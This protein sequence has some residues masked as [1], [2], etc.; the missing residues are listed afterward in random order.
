M[1]F[2]L[3]FIS[4]ALSFALPQD[5]SK[6][7]V[8]GSGRPPRSQFVTGPCDADIECGSDCCEVNKKICRNLLA[9]DNKKNEACLDGRTNGPVG[10]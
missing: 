10:V 9:L 7:P 3:A 4:M 5:P 1:Y 2:T 8:T 6:A